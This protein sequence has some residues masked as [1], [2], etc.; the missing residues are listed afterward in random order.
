MAELHRRA[1]KVVASHD[2]VNSQ[3]IR[4][5]VLLRHVQVVV[6]CRCTGHVLRVPS[7]AH[8]ER[9]R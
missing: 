8:N 1:L 3:A 5:S 6:A 9:G 7:G 2:A 4:Q